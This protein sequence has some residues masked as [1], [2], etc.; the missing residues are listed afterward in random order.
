MTYRTGII[1]L[2]VILFLIAMG[3]AGRMDY[4]DAVMMEKQYHDMV[5]QGAWPNYKQVP[6]RCDK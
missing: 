3:V 1:I 5:C 2:G 6:V 4:D